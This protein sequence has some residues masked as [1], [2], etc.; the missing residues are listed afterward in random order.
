V[1]DVDEDHVVG[2]LRRR[3]GQRPVDVALAQPEARIATELAAEGDQPALEPGDQLREQLDHLH[4]GD[5]LR[6]Q[7]RARR[8]AVG[9]SGL[10][11]LRRQAATPA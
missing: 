7:R 6:V 3:S 2:P 1:I 4:A 10:A 11:G 9:L 5:V 8:P